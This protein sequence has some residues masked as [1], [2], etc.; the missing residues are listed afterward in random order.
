MTVF[1]YWHSCVITIER[2]RIQRRHS[3]LK[4]ICDIMKK[5]HNKS[6]GRNSIR[7]KFK[8]SNNKPS[9]VNAYNTNDKPP[10][11]TCRKGHSRVFLHE[12]KK[13][14]NN[15]TQ[16]LIKKRGPGRPPKIRPNS[17]TSAVVFESK[18]T[19]QENQTKHKGK[20][21]TCMCAVQ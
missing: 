19:H 2:I 20:H 21:G 7:K 1:I 3:S 5:K 13:R 10:T 14:G 6:R 4:H 17:E 15:S 18:I 12:R 11:A 16:K 8:I 9:A